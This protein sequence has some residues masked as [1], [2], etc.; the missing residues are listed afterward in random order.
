VAA[1]EDL[2]KFVITKEGES[3]K[4]SRML[5][6]QHTSSHRKGPSPIVKAIG[7]GGMFNRKNPAALARQED[8]VRARMSAASNSYQK[9]KQDMQGLKSEYFNLQ[10]PRTLRVGRWRFFFIQS[11]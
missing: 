6:P 3:M 10:L 8:D 11:H 2:E 1:Q 4:D 5:G 7:K 9:T